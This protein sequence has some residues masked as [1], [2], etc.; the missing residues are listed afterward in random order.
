M[1]ASA[2]DL[3]MF[4]DE[5]FDAALLMGPLTTSWRT[6]TKALPNRIAADTTSRGRDFRRL[7]MPCAAVRDLAKWSPERLA[8]SD[9]LTRLLSDGTLELDAGSFTDFYTAHLMR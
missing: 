5:Q 7:C 2:T 4:E 3:S 6:G 1:Y 9:I 8:D